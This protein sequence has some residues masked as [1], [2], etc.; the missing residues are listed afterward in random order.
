MLSKE[1]EK[2]KTNVN[3][4]TQNCRKFF[5]KQGAFSLYHSKNIDSFIK[6]AYD[7]VLKKCFEDFLPDSNNIPFC[8]LA[9]KAYATNSLCFNENISLIF[10][11]KDVKAFNLKPM[12][13]EFIEILNDIGLQIEQVILEK[14]GLNNASNELKTS[15]IQTRFICGSKTLFKDI[16]AKFEN[17]LKENKLEFASLLFE[18]FK[19]FNLPFIRQEFN[20]KKDFGGLNHLRAL[21]NLL[22]LYKESPKNYALNFMDEKN[23]SKL[24]LAGD[25]LLSLKSAMNLQQNK[26]EDEFLLINVDELSELMY[27]KSKKNFDAKELLVQKALQSMHTI[28]FYTH[29]LVARLKN[30]VKPKSFKNLSEALEFLLDLKDENISFDITLIFEFKNLKYSKKELE[31]C[32]ILFE[33]IFYKKHSFCLL[34][35]L[36]DSE[37]LKEFCKPLAGVRFLSDEYANYSFDEQVFLL[38]REFEKVENENEILKSLSSEKKMILKLSIILSA[39]NSENEISL[40]SVFRAYCSKFNIKNEI[41][42]FG[43]KIFKNNN[44][45]KDLIEKEDIYNQ[46]IISNLVSKLENLETL[47]L[48]YTLSSLKAKALNYNSFYFKALDRLLENAKEGFKDENLLEESSRRV[49]KE[50]TLKRSKIFLEQNEL[51]QDKITHIK[52][53]LFIVKNSFEDIIKIS[54]IAQENEFKFWFNNETNLS[55]Q[56]IAPFNFNVSLILTSLLNLNLI[57]MNLFELFDDKIY[58]RFEYDNIIN[59]EQKSKLCEL[60]NSN[61]TKLNT[62]KIKK[63]N[64]KKDELKLD[65]NY[66]KIYAKL[67]LNTKDQQGLMAYLMNVFQEFELFLYTAKIQTIRQRTRNVFI[68]QKNENIEKNKQ[69]L[70]NSLISE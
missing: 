12:I 5:L 39:I 51:L 63:P 3:S 6:K 57:F 1:L 61:L 54:K 24:R 38:L 64:I 7:L 19:E 22:T 26:D 27:K 66:S 10:V 17:I 62:K 49:K 56:I 4:Y 25:F 47:E 30:P 34:K 13:K 2:F 32:F 18:N 37:I 65:L 41:L 69:N 14:D 58:L 46:V 16:K 31:K 70:I 48:L 67:S 53:H 55:L 60:L 29:Y 50:L 68:F 8:V 44:A 36:L 35:L 9:S 33:K 43:L 15:I 42:E 52:S 20:I 23:L 40:A 21:E 45:L 11:Y 28:G 59:D